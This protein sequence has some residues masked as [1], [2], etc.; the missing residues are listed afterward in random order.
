MRIDDVEEKWFNE[1]VNNVN[2]SQEAILIIR[3]YW[4]N[5]KTQK[6]K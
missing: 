4:D 3:R 2:D 1:T 5:I 6:K